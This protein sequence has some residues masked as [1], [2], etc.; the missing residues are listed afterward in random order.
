MTTAVKDDGLLLALLAC[1]ILASRFFRHLQLT[2]Y[3]VYHVQR[4]DFGPLS[5]EAIELESRGSR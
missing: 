4:G 1:C 2:Y 3:S 5:A